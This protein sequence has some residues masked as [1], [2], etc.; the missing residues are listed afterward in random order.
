MLLN[1]NDLF[2]NVDFE[3]IHDIEKD[4]INLI[5]NNFHDIVNKIRD[6]KELTNEDINKFLEYA[7]EIVIKYTNTSN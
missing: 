1:N 2:K 6:N 3:Y 5:E 4:I 7:K